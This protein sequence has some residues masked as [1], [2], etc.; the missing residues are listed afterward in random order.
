MPALKDVFNAPDREQAENR[1]EAMILRL[2]N[3]SPELAD[4]LEEN[5]P[6]ALSVFSFP[7]A[8]RRRIKST[9]S[10]ERLNEEIRRR[11][12]VIRIFPNRQ[13]C[14]RMITALCLEKDE[15]WTT[16]KIYLNMELLTKSNNTID[17]YNNNNRIDNDITEHIRIAG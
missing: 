5:A 14:I 13:S 17:A 2:Q 15:E 11:T 7:E 3:S 9:N 4:W 16:G 1:L 6:E 12:R 10:L 8:H